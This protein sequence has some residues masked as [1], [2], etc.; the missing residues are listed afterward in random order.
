MCAYTHTGGLH[1]QRW[2]SQDGIEPNFDA[3]ELEEWLNSSELFAAM[4][5]L[6]VVQMS[7]DGNT[8]EA[9][10]QLIEKRW[11]PP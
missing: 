11:P 9:I 8:G 2:Q 5:G 4:S 1:L 3:A 10:L 6:E 7:E